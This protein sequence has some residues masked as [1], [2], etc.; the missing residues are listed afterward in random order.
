MHR[1]V[2]LAQGNELTTGQTV[3]TNSNWIAEQL[4]PLGIEVVRVVTVPDDLA[5]LI[6]VLRDAVGRAPLVT[7][8]YTHLTLPT[9]A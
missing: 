9:K 1:V 4:F 2:L 3:D 5:Q 7:V 8:S 6:E